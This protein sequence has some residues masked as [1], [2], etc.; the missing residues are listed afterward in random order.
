MVKLRNARAERTPD[1]ACHLDVTKA[2]FG[3][4][5]YRGGWSGRRARTRGAQALS[6]S[7][8]V[9]RPAEGVRMK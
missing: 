7:L 2:C 9:Q 6:F 8:V 5:G 1:S 4:A 3:D